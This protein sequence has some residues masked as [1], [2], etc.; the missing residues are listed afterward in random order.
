MCSFASRTNQS[1]DNDWLATFDKVDTIGN[2]ITLLVGSHNDGRSATGVF[3][4][5]PFLW[6]CRELEMDEEANRGI[7]AL[8]GQTPEHL[9][10]TAAVPKVTFL[11][12]MTFSHPT[13][14]LSN[15][16]RQ[17]H[18]NWQVNLKTIG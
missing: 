3:K 17:R 14:R 2:Y 13:S 18:Q 5:A 4:N 8:S 15:N 1:R 16:H 7:L 12:S 11:R 6:G 10:V 9:S